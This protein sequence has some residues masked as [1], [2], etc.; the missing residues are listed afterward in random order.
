VS[1][2]QRITLGQLMERHGRVRIPIIQRDYAQGRSTQQQ[3]RDDFIDR[4]SVALSLSVDDPA[5][6]L[7]LDFIYGSIEGQNRAFQP[8]DGQQRLTTLF[9]MHWYCAWADD[10][11]DA[12]NSLFVDG[13]RSRFTYRVRS[14]S[15]EFFDALVTFR[16]DHSPAQTESVVDLIVDRPWYFR[17]WR[18]DP[19]VQSVLVML[20][21]LHTRLKDRVGLFGRL[22]DSTAPAITFQLLDLDNFGLSD[23]LYIKMNARGK[24]LTPFETF[25]ARYEHELKQF[26]HDGRL[27]I[28]PNRFTI[29]EYVSR[30]LDNTW[31]DLFWATRDRKSDAFDG[32][33]MNVFRAVALVTRSAEEPVRYQEWVNQLRSGRQS[34]FSEFHANGWLDRTFT[35]TLIHLL[36]QWSLD[37]SSLHEVLDRSPHFNEKSIFE[38]IIKQGGNL[39]YTEVVLFAAYAGYLRDYHNQVDSVRLARFLRIIHNLAVNTSYNR[40]EDVRRSMIG[41]VTLLAKAERI[42]EFLAEDES[43]AA[44]FS[45]KQVEEEKLKAR[46][47]LADDTW[48]ALLARAEQHPYFRGQIEFLLSFA[49]VTTAAEESHPATWGA[50]KHA[51]LRAGVET[52][53]AI[54]N[55][56]FG[57]GG[58]KVLPEARWQRALLSLGNYLMSSGRNMS[59]LTS[60]ATDVEGSWKRYLRSPSP[61]RDI[62]AELWARLDPAKPL[63]PQLDHII[64]SAVDLDEF[65]RVL[66][67]TPEA[68]I[69]CENQALRFEDGLIYLLKRTQRN[70][71]HAELYSYC[72]SVHL[73]REKFFHLLVEYDP[74]IGTYTPPR[75]SVTLRLGNQQ[76]RIWVQGIKDSYFSYVSVSDVG[77]V[78][79]EFALLLQVSGF[80]IKDEWRMVTLGR[81]GLLDWL[82]GIDMRLD[83]ANAS[84]QA[85]A[86]ST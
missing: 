83:A 4:L 75:M 16:P 84:M 60:A 29:A 32:A 38:K 21:S 82:K 76:L 53:L 14:S 49:G 17:S 2:D 31:S 37:G 46:L 77:K 34:N 36:D 80:A 27:P 85:A 50:T 66:V 6:P 41:L 51:E 3:V 40:S 10:A 79:A 30:R 39:A 65:R 25:K 5:R 63:E 57:S 62:L 22:V 81:E 74:T 67:D 23:D 55:S 64:A 78:A 11:W 70:G 54:A 71:A 15:I 47:V 18:L 72:A 35:M 52:K 68:I 86:P 48:R 7:N 58:L 26:D 61:K 28:G 12:F 69:Y 9:L 43:Q 33:L 20:E 42:E 1:I 59:F 56:M 45:D 24:P 44:G 8:L 73:A 13:T 19:T